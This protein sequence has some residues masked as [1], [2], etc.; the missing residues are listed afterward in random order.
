M[1]KAKAEKCR[2]SYYYFLKEFIDVTIHDVV[3]WNW[4]LQ[5]L[6]DKV[7]EYGRAIIDR[8][9]PPKP[10]LVVNVPPGTT[11]STIFTQYFPLWLW[12]N[13]PRIVTIA[14]SYSSDLSL[15]HAKSSRDVIRSNK[16]KEMFPE[17]IAKPDQD[18]AGSYANTKGGQRI[19]SSVGGTITGKHAHVIIVD[20]PLN[21]EEAVSQADRKAANRFIRETLPSRKKD[22]ENTPTIVVMQRLHEE[23]PSGMLL[24]VMKDKVEHICLPA[25]LSANNVKP[26]EWQQ[27]YV[28]GM[29]DPI[30]LGRLVLDGFRQILGSIGYAQQF[31]QRGVPQ[32]GAI[33]KREWFAKRITREQFLRHV[34][35]SGCT[36]NYF[37]DTAYTQKQ[38]NDP[39]FILGTTMFDGN[40]YIVSRWKGHE[41]FPALLKTIPIFV[42]KHGWDAK[43]R[44]VIEPKASGQ[45]IG[46]QLKK[47]TL[48]NILFSKPPNDD[49]ITRASGVAPF[50]ESG[51]VIM[52]EGDW[53]DDFIQHCIGFP[54]AKHDE[55]VDTL[56]M[57]IDDV[58]RKDNHKPVY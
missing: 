41:E 18:A 37:I 26:N 16:F 32:E 52:V 15:Q 17:I 6:C 39:S 51:R 2:R 20:D 58:T 33:W 55:E 19:S 23:D 56:V 30:R 8:K 25:E 31:D 7:Q 9:P 57:A 5:K 29:L 35:S 24:D 47:N 12:I 44:I 3:V 4:H 54:N 28:D 53:N 48:F 14:L 11:K 49:K 10:Y 13:D 21:V 38:E 27:F 1:L 43:T 36:M 22:K 34:Y 42:E 45:S 40:L 50:L 46:Q